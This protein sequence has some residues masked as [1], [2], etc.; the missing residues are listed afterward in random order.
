MIIADQIEKCKRY[1][2]ENF[3]YLSP[4]N[5]ILKNCNSHMLYET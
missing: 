5:E 3:S 4:K 1:N 2:T